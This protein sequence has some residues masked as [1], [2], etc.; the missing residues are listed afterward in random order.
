MIAAI[1]AI[2]FVW[3]EPRGIDIDKFIVE[4]QEFIETH[5][6]YPNK[7]SD[8]G[9]EKLLA[10]RVVRYRKK[11]NS[12]KLAS[13]EKKKLDAM[14]FVWEARPKKVKEEVVNI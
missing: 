4:L 8:N 13:E 10:N 11:N 14:G 3:E 1:D 12:G 5:G 9:E 2:D 7:R 6:T